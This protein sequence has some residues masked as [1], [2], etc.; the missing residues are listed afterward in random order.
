GN[1]NNTRESHTASLLS[2]GKVLVSGGF[3][4]SGI[5]NSAELY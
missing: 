1:M 3:D 2:N 4:N 5:L